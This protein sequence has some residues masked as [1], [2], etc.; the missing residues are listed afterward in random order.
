MLIE[1]RVVGYTSPPLGPDLEFDFMGL[2][3]I[4]L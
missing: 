1:I 4:V 2:I 3:P